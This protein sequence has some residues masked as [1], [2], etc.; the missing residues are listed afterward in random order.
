MISIDWGYAVSKKKL[1]RHEPEAYI[2]DRI[3]ALEYEAHSAH[4]NWRHQVGVA[5]EALV[6]YQDQLATLKL[7]REVRDEKWR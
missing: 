3:Q 4:A 1:R 6:T 7:M 5:R 2:N